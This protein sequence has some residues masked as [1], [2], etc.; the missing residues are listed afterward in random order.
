MDF[1]LSDDQLAIQDAVAKFFQEEWNSDIR[2]D[3][4][5]DGPVKISD[6]IWQQIVEMGWIGI[7]VSEEH[8]G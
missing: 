5:D 2:R 8:G 1:Q 7:A 4:L 3:A 6:E